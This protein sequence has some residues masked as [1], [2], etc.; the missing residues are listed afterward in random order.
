[1]INSTEFLDGRVTL[2]SGDCLARMKSLPDGSVD[3]CV[4][5]P[6]YHLTSIVERFGADGAAP[7]TQK[8]GAAGA[9]ARASAGFMSKTWDGGDVAF[10]VETW[11]EVLRVLKPGGHIVAFSGTRT[12][13]RMAVAI[14]DA[15][16][17]IRDQLAWVYGTG[18]P[19]SHSVSKGIDDHLFRE[20]L[21]KDKALH[22][23]YKRLIRWA[24]RRDKRGT[25]TGLRGRI[26]TAFKRIGGFRGEFVGTETLVNDMRNSALLNVG[27]GEERPAYDRDIYSNATPEAAE[28]DGW[29]TALKP[30]WEPICLARKPMVGTVAEN[31]L[32]YGTGGINAG[33]CRVGT[34]GGTSRGEQGARLND[35]KQGFRANSII[36]EINAGRWPA[37]IVTDGS[38]EVEAAFPTAGG[39]QGRTTKAGSGESTKNVYGQ[40]SR[41]ASEPRGDAG[42]A[43]R[44]F[45]S[46]K[47]DGDDRLGSK[48]PTVKP[49][50]LMRWLVRLVCRKGGTVLD[51]FAGTGTTGEA[52]FWEGCNAILIERE[53]EYQR[54]IAKRMSL[55]LAGPD[56]KK[57]A[58]TVLEPAEGLPLFGEETVAHVAK[59]N[60]GGTAGLRELR[61]RLSVASRAQRK[62]ESSQPAH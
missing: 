3:A 17:E 31:V 30:A 10:R 26:E 28:W 21:A 53:V 29:G 46:S 38:A 36:N 33:G 49:V 37:N 39:A 1:M 52:A 15:G 22:A 32:A 48:H 56:T 60:G 43:V 62:T 8:D 54:D 45:Y 34:D 18:F 14:E 20:W 24:K 55:V 12:Y 16:F 58:R 25:S 44:F 2:L 61:R 59:I 50:D 40:Y 35:D 5:D 57:R 6:P 19:K 9:Y 42:S 27:K 47:A 41:A 7:A 23:R 4:C 13:H 11:V 51:P